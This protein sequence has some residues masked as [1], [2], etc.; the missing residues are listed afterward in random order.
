MI[1]DHLCCIV[2]FTYFR[3]D[4][5]RIAV[6]LPKTTTSFKIKSTTPKIN[7]RTKFPVWV[8]SLPELDA[9]TSMA[10]YFWD[11][12]NGCVYG[13]LSDITHYYRIA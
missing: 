10:A 8:N 2:S 12:T 11:Q 5:I 1:F 6:C 4:I 3:N 13:Y 7:S 9:D